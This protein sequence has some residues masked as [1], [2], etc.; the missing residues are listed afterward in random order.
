MN[1]RIPGFKFNSKKHVAKFNLYQPNSQ[2]KIRRER[3]V[4]ADSR[5]EA[6]DLWKEFREELRAAA[7]LP[8]AQTPAVASAKSGTITFSSFIA[9]YLDKICARKAKKTLTTYR[10][11]AM[12]RLVPFFGAFS[13]DA[14]RS[15]DVEDFMVA[16]R[17]SGCSPAYTNNCVRTMKALIGHAVRRQLLDASPLRDKIEFEDVD[18]PELELSDDERV[19]F[20][21]AFDDEAAFRADVAGR[22]ARGHNVVS[23]HFSSPRKFGF[24]PNPESDA[25]RYRYERFRALKPIFV[26]ALETGLR[27]SDLL[28]LEWSQIDLAGGFMR[29]QM[30]KT[31]KWAV[32]PI[33]QFCREALDEC[34]RRSVVSRYVFITLEGKRVPEIAVRRAFARVKQIAGITRRFRF[35]DLRHSAACNLANASVPLQVIQKILGHKSIR[36]TER[37]ARVNDSAIADARRAIDARN[38]QLGIGPK[39]VATAQG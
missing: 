32:I 30:Q 37:Y 25:T 35:H 5:D 23:A 28:N 4:P 11:I 27:K 6:V 15:C 9:T 31:K 13:L 16:T 14:I 17:E 34:R 8:S 10:T 21:A 33:S 2:G 20:L 19:A 39:D 24:G 22:S 29:V 12:T 3:T 38:T 1:G 7:E 18:L 26:I 36:M